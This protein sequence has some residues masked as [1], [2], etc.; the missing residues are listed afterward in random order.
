MSDFVLTPAA[1]ADVSRIID[2]LEGDNPSAILKVVDA[3]DEAMQL[4]AEN[5]MIGHIGGIWLATM[6]ASGRSSNT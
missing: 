6:F 3:L 5:P 2:F 1:Q 4:L